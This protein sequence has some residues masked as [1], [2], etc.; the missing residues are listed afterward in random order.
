MVMVAY[1]N[2][3]GLQLESFLG[4]RQQRLLI[5]LGVQDVLD[6]RVAKQTEGHLAREALAGLLRLAIEAEI[7]IARVIFIDG[8]NLMEDR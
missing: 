3:G 1:R 8:P 2:F 7:F 6:Y 5:E 4:A